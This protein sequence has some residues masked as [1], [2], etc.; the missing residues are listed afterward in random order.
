MTFQ[1]PPLDEPNVPAKFA[2][3]RISPR[4]IVRKK[5][6]ERLRD[7]Q[8]CALTLVTGSAGFGKTILLVQWRQELMKAGAEVAWLALTADDRYREVF[9]RDLLGALAR[10]G[11]EA[12]G[13]L[14]VGRNESP[15][16]IEPVAATIIAGVQRVAKDL[17]LFID[18]FQHVDD[19]WVHELMQKLVS[20]SP[21]NLHIVIASRITPPLGLSRLRVSGQL[22]EV[23]FEDLLF[24]LDET[25]AFFEQ[26]LTT[27]KLTA[28]ELQLIQ[29]VTRGWPASL[30]LVAI[31]LR[32]RPATRSQLTVLLRRS[33]ALQSYLAEDVIAPAP[34]EMI[35]FLETLA[36]LRRF[37]AALAA[38]A[39]QNARSDDLLRRAEEE[40][41]LIQRVETDDRTP[42]YRFHPLLGEFLCKRLA[43]RGDDVV[44]ALHRRASVWFASHQMLVDAVRHANLGGDLGL[45]VQTI[46]QSMPPDWRFSAVCAMVQLLDH[47]PQD[48]LVAHPQLSFLACLSCALS[49]RPGD[50]QRWLEQLRRSESTLHPGMHAQL[51][52]AEATIATQRD[53]SERVIELLAREPATWPVNRT[54]RYVHIA[55][56]VTAY[57]HVG[58]LREALSLHDEHAVP[59][60]DQGSEIA[61]MF[62]ATLPA[63]H[64]VHG[65][66]RETARLASALLE[67]AEAAHGRHSVPAGLCAAMLSDAYY[68]LD[69]IG[70]A[71]DVLANR[72]GLLGASWP[73]VM[74]EAS[75]C[76]ARLDRL[77]Q[78]SEAALAFL[79]KQA[80]HFHDMNLP[81]PAAVMLA[82]QTRILLGD[83][84][85]VRA[86]G[87]VARLKM[88]A[89]TPRG[90]ADTG[91]EIRAV[92]MLTCA[93]LALVDCN[94]KEALAAL[95]E[96]RAF[97]RAAGRA[98]IL[99]QVN[100]LAAAAWD[101]LE[102]TD[103]ARQ[104]LIEALNASADLGLVRT[105]IDD[106]EPV[107]VHL[108]TLRG[109][110]SLTS[111]AASL[112]ETVLEKLDVSN[113]RHAS[114][115]RF[116]KSSTVQSLQNESVNLTPREREI[117]LLISQA[118]SNKRIALTL[119]ISVGTTKWNVRN[120][121]N[122]LGVSTRYD[123]MVWAREHGY[124][125]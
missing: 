39:T 95:D 99:V 108:A 35:A 36:P 78:G 79:Q 13:P 69:L 38:Q 26:N 77:D 27:M 66:V 100:L 68:E 47:L 65:H 74:I 112:L 104:S 75:L 64:L 49:A 115:V 1:T 56:L 17:Y 90:A 8:H 15:W 92:A 106:G 98:R 22:A 9:C 34:P 103:A 122:K 52:L 18:D 116:G 7:A 88:L 82:E 2:P 63:A 107:A 80:E 125:E 111:S 110:P 29:D 23:G 97:A 24:S 85:H 45:A 89:N 5:Q 109:D 57:A 105:F 12:D 25:Q 46:E 31:M 33:G 96:V 124:I 6:L 118:M 40:F 37:N 41:L 3:P 121:L 44:Q 20:H 119:N 91:A 42:W 113:D 30:Q 28:N 101:S 83:G 51:A 55:A 21:A 61:L 86:Q 123:A 50:A 16:P 84:D 48:S 114:P 70:D 43:Q 32:N 10:L 71:R 60:A 87:V 81:R 54:L 94:A 67:Q 102:Q 59:S 93:R 4:H 76:H 117:L 58:R 53:Q 11:V 14:A 120:I 72:T 19:A 62:E 73:E